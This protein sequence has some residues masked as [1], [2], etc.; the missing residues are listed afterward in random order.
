LR[1]SSDKKKLNDV[2]GLD[3]SIPAVRDQVGTIKHKMQQ[4]VSKHY[5]IRLGNI[6]WFKL[7][8]MAKFSAK[9]GDKLSNMY[10]TGMEKLD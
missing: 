1:D 8:C 7:G 9:K 6:V 2:S 4:E 10:L 5:I 3:I